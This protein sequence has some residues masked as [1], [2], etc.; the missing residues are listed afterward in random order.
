MQTP[1]SLLLEA[2]PEQVDFGHY[3]DPRK[4]EHGIDIGGMFAKWQTHLAARSDGKF[5]R[6]NI[7][8]A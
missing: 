4:A 8:K 1:F 5:Y 6:P 2:K 7:C 3:H